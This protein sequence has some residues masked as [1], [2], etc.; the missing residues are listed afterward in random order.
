MTI[1]AQWLR[2]LGEEGL[3]ALLERRPEVFDVLPPSSLSELADLL[4][5]PWSV[6]TAMRRLDRPTLQ[7]AEA[8]AALGG[9]TDRAALDRLLGV[10]QRCRAEDVERAL[11]TLRDHALLDG[12]ELC[13]LEAARHAWPQPLGLGVPSAMVLTGQTAGELKVLARNLGLKPPARKADMFAAVLAAL[14]DPARVRSVV[15]TAPAETREM[16]HKVA[17]TGE[18]VASFGHFS[19][20][21]G[22]VATPIHWAIARGLLVRYGE[23]DAGLQM[24]AEVALALRGP[25]YTAPF[26]PTAPTPA[27]VAVDPALVSR[28]AAAAGSA[29][30]RLVTAVLDEIDRTPLTLLRS[31]GVGVRE[32]RR[33]AKR[34]HCPPGEVRLAVAVAERARLLEVGMDSGA[35]TGGY[36]A[37]LREEP[38]G[39]LAALLEAWWSLPLAPLADAE[40]AWSPEVD[41]DGVAGL[42]ETLLAE[43][44]RQP[45]AAPADPGALVDLV[46]WRRPYAYRGPDPRNQVLACWQEAA[47]LGATAAGALSPAGQALVDGDHAALLTAL[48]VIGSAQRSVRV[49]ADMTAV[50]TGTPAAE[51]AAL[52]DFAAERESVGT[53]STWRFT[54]ASVRGAFDAGYDADRLLAEL[55]AVAVGDLPQP[56]AYLIRDVARRHGVVRGQDVRCCLRSD[57]P[58]LLA[59]IAVDRRLRGIGL[60][61]VAPTVLVGA[62][63]LADTLAALRGAGYAPVAEAADGT[64]VLERDPRRRPAGEAVPRGSAQAAAGS[65]GPDGSSGPAGPRAEP[66]PQPDMRERARSMLAKPDVVVRAGSKTMRAIQAAARL[67]ESQ[68]RLLAHAVETGGPVTIDY[69]NAEDGYSR[70]VIEYAMLSGDA[71]IAWCRLREGEGVFHLARV[72]AVTPAVV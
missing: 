44:A 2:R 61:A 32:L 53:A 57:D 35:V 41:G 26:E 56:L 45:G 38:A 46:L 23:W 19:I 54:P 31:G 65:A 68:A 47:A 11:S 12:P 24:P 64:P 59:E 15:A 16:L 1:D 70:R 42:R 37:W 63:P 71:V 55:S 4:T 9:E 34:V 22:R 52:L 33:L 8:I 72:L 10:P 5:K 3:T 69:L 67:P 62:F 40:A 27:R 21:Y 39:R 7:V 51:L 49:Q 18:E 43:A 36:R 6:V 28:E 13:L 14:R 48:E 66:S 50:V 17:L 60:R 58:A 30:L 29:A 25:D 20:E